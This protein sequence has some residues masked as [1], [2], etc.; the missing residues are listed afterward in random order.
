MNFDTEIQEAQE[1]LNQFLGQLGCQSSVEL[2]QELILQLT[3]L[4]IDLADILQV[5]RSATVQSLVTNSIIIDPPQP[6][7][8]DLVAL[9]FQPMPSPILGL[10]PG[11]QIFL[12]LPKILGGDYLTIPIIDQDQPY[13]IQLQLPEVVVPTEIGIGVSFRR[14]RSAISLDPLEMTIQPSAELKQMQRVLAEHLAG[15]WRSTNYFTQVS[16]ILDNPMDFSVGI[17]FDLTNNA[18]TLPVIIYASVLTQLHLVGVGVFAESIDLSQNWEVIYIDRE[19]LGKCQF[20]RL[21]VG[22]IANPV[23]TSQIHIPPMS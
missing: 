17:C 3:Q 1:L 15:N 9:R 2:D 10:V 5:L 6:Q 13:Q 14:D 21:V 12:Q 11:D 16:Q 23:H 22:S 19:D 8:G 4:S 7:G 20:L 18:E